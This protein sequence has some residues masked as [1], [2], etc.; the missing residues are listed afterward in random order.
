MGFFG[1]FFSMNYFM[2]PD[3]KIML[4]V[5]GYPIFAKKWLYIKATLPLSVQQS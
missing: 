3:H 2:S 1:L 4:R 5:Q